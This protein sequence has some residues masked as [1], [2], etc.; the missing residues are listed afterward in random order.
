MKP[1]IYSGKPLANSHTESKA[2][3]GKGQSKGSKFHRHQLQGQMYVLSRVSIAEHSLL[4]YNSD[5]CQP[6]DSLNRWLRPNRA[7]QAESVTGH[8]CKGG[9]SETRCIGPHHQPTL[10]QSTQQPCW[11][12]GCLD[13]VTPRTIGWVH[14]GAH[15][16]PQATPSLATSRGWPTR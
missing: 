5:C 4:T 1:C 15:P 13:K 6:T 11:D 7:V 10:S 16:A 8:Q 14:V 3:S 12:F 9:Q 2:E